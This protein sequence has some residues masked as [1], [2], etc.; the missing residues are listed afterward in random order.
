V[1]STAA[2]GIG[3]IN[4]AGVV[5]TAYITNAGIGYSAEPTVTFEAPTGAGVGVGT[6]SYVFNETITGQTS[7]TT[8]RVKEWDSVNNT[9]EISIVDGK[10]TDGETILGSNSGALYAVLKTNTDNLVS[11]FDDNDNIQTQ[12]DSII[13]F[14]EKNPF[15]MP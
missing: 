10:F 6:G 13:D 7:G 1:G 14:T 5:T 12:A 3:Y 2:Y 15:G 4:S 8:A 11:G 9:L